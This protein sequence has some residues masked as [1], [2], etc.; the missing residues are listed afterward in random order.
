MRLV[1]VSKSEGMIGG[2]ERLHL[3]VFWAWLGLVGQESY[4]LLSMKYGD[5]PPSAQDLSLSLC[6]T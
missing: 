1:A 5:H 6:V 4:F 3:T 2:G